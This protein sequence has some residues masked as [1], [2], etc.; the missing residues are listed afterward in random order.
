MQRIIIVA[1][2]A[3]RASVLMSRD[4]IVAPVRAFLYDLD[5]CLFEEHKPFSAWA[6]CQRCNGVWFVGFFWLLYG[7]SRKTVGAIAAMGLQV[8]LASYFFPDMD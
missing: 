8:A 4:T 6:K 7:W 3:F 1:L 5:K 2:A